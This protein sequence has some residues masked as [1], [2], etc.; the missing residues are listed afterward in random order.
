MKSIKLVCDSLTD[1]P[2][3]I[4]DKYNI[5]IVPLSVLFGDI[6]YIDGVDISKNDFYSLMRNN[7][8]LP[9]TS[10]ATYSKFKEI[11]ENN[12]GSYESILYIGGS[13]IA[14]GTFQS[15]MLTISDMDNSNIYAFDTMNLSIG[16]AQ[17]VLKAAK[18]IEDNKSIEEIVDTLHELRDN[19]KVLFSVDTLEYL[20]KGGRVSMAQAS[21]GN[22]LNIK[23]ILQ[24]LDG[25]VMPH[26][27]IRGKKQV[28]SKFIS[29]IKEDF[30]GDLSNHTL[31]IGCG[32]NYLELDEF[33][34]SLLRE[35]NNCE[36]LTVN[37][38]SC[39][40]AHS[41]PSILGFS[42]L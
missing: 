22:L 14:S 16:S 42:I 7:D 38:G 35:F 31:I 34:N 17:F 20:Q 40:C 19:V 18:L 12:K 2:K 41:G 9:K 8:I 33:K 28:I 39:I 10:Q 36:I 23:P 4:I 5:D 24:V 27:K 30:S 15:A 11:F 32:D 37:V 26:S 21:L 29:S 25:T 1:L 13:S 3:D 6:E